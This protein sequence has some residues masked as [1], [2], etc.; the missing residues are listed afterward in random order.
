[1]TPEITGWIDVSVTVRHGMPHW[2]GHP[3]IARPRL[4][5]SHL[6]MRILQADR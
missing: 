6:A 2:P 1:M 5:V 3:P 4:T